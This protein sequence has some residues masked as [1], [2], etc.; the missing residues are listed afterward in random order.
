MF[1]FLP[2]SRRGL[3]LHYSTVRENGSE[4]EFIRL[5]P[6]GRDQ[7]T[8]RWRFKLD[9]KFAIKYKAGTPC[10]RPDVAGSER[11]WLILL[12]MTWYL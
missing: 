9:T 6:R 10:T 4:I 3:I 1:L 5:L 12:L 2:Y 8:P 7:T 11:C